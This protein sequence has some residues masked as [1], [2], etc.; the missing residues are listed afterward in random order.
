M[1]HELPV[2]C[3][4]LSDT[5]DARAKE[6]TE[7]INSLL[8]RAYTLQRFT[9]T[10]LEKA[11]ADLD[12][13]LD[14]SS[15]MYWLLLARINE[16]AL[17]CAGH[18]ADHAEYRA[19]GDLMFNP[20]E[21]HVFFSDGTRSI[22]QRHG[23]LSE[24]Y[25]D[26]GF[27]HSGFT[28]WFQREACLKT[29]SPPL[30]IQLVNRLKRS[31]RISATY[32]KRVETKM[33]QVANT[34]NFLNAWGLQGAEDIFN[35]RQS[36]AGKRWALVKSN[37]CRFETDLFVQLGESIRSLYST[38]SPFRQPGRSHVPVESV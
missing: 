15:P 2:L 31:S 6:N 24:L 9:E 21:V 13:R 20:R 27:D 37:L 14:D 28:D 29:V 23:R 33:Q 32:L 25:N 17:L 1:R 4:S 22:K 18:Y 3:D 5:Q 34:L 19:V 36:I 11:L 8:D 26:Y 7:E 30:L 12:N 10:C 16:W 38:S 35:L